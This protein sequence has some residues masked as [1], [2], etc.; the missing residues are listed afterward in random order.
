MLDIPE[1]EKQWSK[2]HFKKMLPRYIGAFITLSLI[3]TGS[4]FAVKNEDALFA[5]LKK[6]P[7]LEKKAP[8]VEVFNPVVMPKEGKVEDIETDIVLGID[9]PYT[10][11]KRYGIDAEDQGVEYQISYT[12]GVLTGL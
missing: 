2:Y 10:I 9:V 4:F 1:L 3:A 5:L 6:T 7:K 11:H 8:K 12:Q